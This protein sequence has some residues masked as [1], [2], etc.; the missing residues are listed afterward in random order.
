LLSACDGARQVA[1][2]RL[3]HLITLG[4]THGPGA[5]AND[6]VVSGLHGDT[7]RVLIQAFGEVPSLPLIYSK[8]GTYL[9]TLG[10]QGDGPE[11]FHR[12]RFTRS[13]P[14]DSLWI[15]DDLPRVLV[16]SPDR[17]YVRTID[18]PMTPWDALVL[19]DGSLLLSSVNA[20]QPLPFL[21]VDAHGLLVR[22]IGIDDSASNS[23]QS[24]R[25]LVRGRDGTFWTM[26][27]S[28]GWRL[29]HWDTAGHP[30]G[31]IER[32]PAW[33]PRYGT[34]AA[35]SRQQA[36]SPTLIGAWFD[37]AGRLWVMG[38]AADPHWARG[39][40]PA[41]ADRDGPGATVINPDKAYDTVI[42][43]LDPITGT[44]LADT[45]F[46]MAYVLGGEPGMVMRVT[47]NPDGWKRVEL[48]RVAFDSTK[49]H[50]QSSTRP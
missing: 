25:Q 27:S 47:R 33:Y 40:G 14:G 11:Q 22:T 6:P 7:Y 37:G 38:R 17:H 45:R 8:D 31:V 43:V 13:G 41:V 19:P 42:E 32:M 48:L 30:L 24:P 20:G 26:P 5:M 44:L 35:G 16:Y 50:F 3:E 39:L 12:A 46:D 15:F 2:I 4:D 36:P 18:L 28:Y 10:T 1:P 49:A 9:G 29:E 23:I 34:Y 21:L